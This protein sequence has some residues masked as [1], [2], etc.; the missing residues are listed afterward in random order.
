MLAQNYAILAL[1]IHLLPCRAM[2][3]NEFVTFMERFLV[4]TVHITKT[5]I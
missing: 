4:N 1:A 5:L 3:C 2:P